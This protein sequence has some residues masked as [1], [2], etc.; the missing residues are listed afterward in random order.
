MFILLLDLMILNKDFKI[1]MHF[2]ILIHSL[3]FN[4]PQLFFQDLRSLLLA[5]LLYAEFVLHRLFYVGYYNVIYMCN[6]AI[7][8]HGSSIEGIVVLMIK[9]IFILTR[10]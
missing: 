2:I 9:L 3:R 1:N 5:F 6:V 7:L 8:E 10:L 4:S